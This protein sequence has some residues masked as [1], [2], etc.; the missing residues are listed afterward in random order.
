MLVFE[1][2]IKG[3]S[4]F[5][6]LGTQQLKSLSGFCTFSALMPWATVFLSPLNQNIFK[7]LIFLVHCSCISIFHHSKP[8]L[9]ASNLILVLLLF[10]L[11]KKGHQHFSIIRSSSAQIAFWATLLFNPL[12]TPKKEERILTGF[13]LISSPFLHQSTISIFLHKKFH[14]Q[15]SNSIYIIPHPPLFCSVSLCFSLCFALFSHCFVLVIQYFIPTSPISS[16]LSLIHSV[17][18]CFSLCF[19]LFFRQESQ[20]LP[21]PPRNVVPP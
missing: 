4:H 1:F 6:L 9:G 2:C 20:C 18:L 11:H 10:K 14:P 16:T 19:A 15:I 5:Q 21:L 3:C 7:A 13:S 17:L 8:H 12:N